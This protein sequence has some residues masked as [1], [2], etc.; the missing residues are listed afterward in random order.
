MAK[1]YRSDPWNYG[2][3]ETG[4]TRPPKKKGCLT[5]LLLMTVI[6]LSGLVSVLSFLNVR[7]FAQLN[8]AK[9]K[10]EDTVSI[11]REM[12]EETASIESMPEETILAAPAEEVQAHLDL[13]PSETSVSTA[14]QDNGLSLQ[15]IYAKNID[16]VVSITCQLS[17][18]SSSGTGVIFSSQ[19]YIVTN[20]HV[21]EDARAITV[22]LTDE[23]QLEA[24][25]IG[26][27]SASDLAVLYVE[28]EDLIA[29]EFGDSTQLRVG[30]SVA[31]IGDPLG[32]E[33]RGTLTNGIVSA[34]NRDVSVGGRTMTLIQTNAAINSGNSGGPLINCY[35]QVIGIN[36]LKIS[37][38][39]SSAGVEGLGF[40]IPSATVKEIV[41][42]LIDQ[43]YVSGR[44]SLGISGESVSNFYQHYYRMPAGLYITYIESDSDA[45]AKGIVTGD[46][47][48]SLGE[49]R[50]TS[51]EDLVSALYNLNPGD[52]VTAIIYRYGM[53]YQVDLTLSEANG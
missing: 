42:Q 43:G 14:T 18:G 17:R 19:G 38:S 10:H 25:V 28:G 15:E 41:D 3:Y 52:S 32:S 13:V 34:I 20:H 47:L 8:N 1:Y 16:S 40:A 9:A 44:P 4:R 45:A 22:L 48:L 36:T 6:A 24:K 21:I 53:Q 2:A 23:R 27:D 39:A 46:I 50:I 51:E 30:D 49:I 11:V 12:A 29:A 5:P 31:A 35:G 7:L 26:A 33:L 37:D